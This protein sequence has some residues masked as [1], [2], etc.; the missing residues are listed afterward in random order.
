MEPM[1]GWFVRKLAAQ[2]I[3]VWSKTPLTYGGV[4]LQSAAREG[5]HIAEAT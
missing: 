4:Q 5:V 2:G 3:C 1:F